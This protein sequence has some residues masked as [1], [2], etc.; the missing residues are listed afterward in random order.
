MN[1]G[2]QNWIFYHLFT[3]S[4]GLNARV[5]KPKIHLYKVQNWSLVVHYFNILELSPNST[6]LL[7]GSWLFCIQHLPHLGSLQCML[8]GSGGLNKEHSILVPQKFELILAC[9]EVLKWV[10]PSMNW[11]RLLLMQI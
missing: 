4:S 1:E 8:G 11:N 3:Y 10:W 9:Q 5:D 6:W 2:W 7:V